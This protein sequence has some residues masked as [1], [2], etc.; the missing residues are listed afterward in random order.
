M[1]DECKGEKFEEV[2]STFA[3]LVL[4][5]KAAIPNRYLADSVCGHSGQK[6]DQ[7]QLLP[8]ILA[9]RNSL[10]ESLKQRKEF[11]QHAHR[12][13]AFLREQE[14]LLQERRSRVENL[15]SNVKKSN[16]AVQNQVRGAWTG[17]DRWAEIL[18]QGMPERPSFLQQSFESSWES[19]KLGGASIAG[20]SPKSLI[21]DLDARVA[22]HE[23]R[24]KRWTAF[25]ASL[26]SA[27]NA[28]AQDLQ[29]SALPRQPTTARVP[30]EK[31]QTL[32]LHAVQFTAAPRIELLRS[33]EM[34]LKSME[35]ELSALGRM[36]PT[37]SQARVENHLGKDLSR[38]ISSTS[39]MTS[40]L[41]TAPIT[42]E[43]CTFGLPSVA[44]VQV[45]VPETHPGTLDVSADDLNST[46]Q[47]R[48]SSQ[49]PDLQLAPDFLRENLEVAEEVA[50]DMFELLNGGTENYSI[51]E[52][53][54]TSL[55]IAERTEMSAFPSSDAGS[56]PDNTQSLTATPTLLPPPTQKNHLGTLLE[57]TR[58][59]MSLLPNLPRNPR[60][61]R[62]NQPRTSLV[63]PVNQ[64]ETPGKPTSHVVDATPRSGSSTPRDKLFSDEAEYASVFKSRPK[65]ALSPALSPERSVMG[66][67]SLLEEGI[68]DITLGGGDESFEEIPLRKRT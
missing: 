16:N 65:V 59:S 36:R 27:R 52:R 64:F 46:K 8:L 61:S 12:Y 4:R 41:R 1:L 10:Q 19:V 21:D 63:F 5:E 29:Q 57:R 44:N 66:L 11:A 33:H 26:E 55:V 49:P 48:N 60:D 30:F 28:K 58:Q 56:S 34:L 53:L 15:P 14:G 54:S 39:Q 43:Q 62:L 7:A 25:Q 13:E 37:P 32:H 20:D 18:L 24:L 9:H 47:S 67:D 51:P 2:L 22:E 38:I 23:T 31:H 42:T 35:G 6:V 50:P 3:T 40:S 68:G 17:D 45:S